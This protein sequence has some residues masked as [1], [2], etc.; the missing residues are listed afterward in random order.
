MKTDTNDVREAIELIESSLPG[1]NWNIG[2]DADG[3]SATLHP[4]GSY[5]VFEHSRIS[6][7]DAAHKA[8]QRLAKRTTGGSA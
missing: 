4:I 7:M 6:A 2:R 1:V 5:G 8:I 3:V